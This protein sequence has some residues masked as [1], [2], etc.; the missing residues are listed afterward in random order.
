MPE[1]SNGA[2]APNPEQHEGQQPQ[3]A[4]VPQ[5]QTTPPAN[6][7]PKP[8]SA[9][10]IIKDFA[11]DRG[12]TVEELVDKFKTYED[13]SKTES[14]KLTTERDEAV[15]KAS[16]LEER[17]REKAGKAAITSEATKANAIDADA[18]YALVSG[19]L[20]YDDDGE[21]T[22]VDDVMKA[23]KADHPKLFKAAAGAGDGGKRSSN[24]ADVTP[25]IGRLQHAYATNSK[26]AA[27][28]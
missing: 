21:P 2:G 11:K 25:G 27:Q 26:T 6:D 12:L 14:E 15:E 1:E 20:E 7:T 19:A 28:R 24:T 8:D 3:G 9:N 22:N 18:V 17:V 5:E 16:R 23:A 10:K 13:A 4:G